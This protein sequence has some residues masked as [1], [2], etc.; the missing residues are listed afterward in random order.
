MS[1]VLD[2]RLVLCTCIIMIVPPRDLHPKSEAGMELHVQHVYYYF[3]FLKVNSNFWKLPQL[4][5]LFFTFHVFVLDVCNPFHK[6][7]IGLTGMDSQAIIGIIVMFLMVMYASI[8]TSSNSQIGK[9]AMTS[10]SANTGGLES[11]TLT[12]GRSSGGDNVNEIEEHRGRVWDDE[13]DAVAYSYSF[14]HFMLFFGILVCHDDYYKLVQVSMAK[15]I[16]LYTFLVF[17]FC[18]SLTAKSS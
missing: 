10:N 14:Y 3:V 5:F 8:R 12:E 7:N 18:M 2:A 1:P 17:S 15:F 4:I 6:Q 16:S 11:T 13:A 9:L